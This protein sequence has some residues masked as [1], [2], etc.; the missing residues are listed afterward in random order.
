MGRASS[1]QVVVW[2]ALHA[3]IVCVAC[4]KP[5]AGATV[6][7]D[8][9][10]TKDTDCKGNRICE[11]GRCGAPPITGTPACPPCAACPTCPEAFSPPQEL[12]V[13]PDTS[14]S[15]RKG[16]TAQLERARALLLDHPDQAKIILYD[17]LSKG[18]TTEE[19][20]VLKQACK[21]TGDTACVNECRH[22]L[23]Q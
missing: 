6:R 1:T 3:C 22:R 15:A 20:N 23:G 19:L 14:A 10:C 17:R 9:G 13:A 5:E 11:Q 16:P 7:A 21:A 18:G 12:L 2:L 8:D 4:S